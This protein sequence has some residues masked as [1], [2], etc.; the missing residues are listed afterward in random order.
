VLKP[1]LHTLVIV[2]GDNPKSGGLA[3]LYRGEISQPSWEGSGCFREGCA[4]V[5]GRAF[6]KGVLECSLRND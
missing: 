2:Q 4:G 6:V 5:V 1:L 3:D